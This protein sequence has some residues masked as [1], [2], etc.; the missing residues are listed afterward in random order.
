MATLA[1]AHEARTLPAA[2]LRIDGPVLAILLAAFAIQV[3]LVLNADLGWLL[4]VCEKMLGG[5]RLGRDVLELNP[6]LS[7]LI[8]MPAAYLGTLLPVPAHLIV[9]AMVLALAWGST[10]LILAG[11]GADRWDAAIRRRAYLAL[12]TLMTIAPGATFAQRE[13]IAM[14]G[15]MPFVAL[16]AARADRLDHPRPAWLTLLAGLGAGLAMCLKPHFAA[17]AGLPLLWAA[18]RQ[19]SLRPLFGR[20][21]WTAAALVIAYFGI[22]LLAY[23]EYFSVY[24]KWAAL[25][26]LPLRKPVSF[27]LGA[28]MV[29]AAGGLAWAL[30]LVCGRDA[31][32]W[33]AAAPW[34]LAALGGFLS[35]VVQ[36]KGFAYMRLPTVVFALAGVVLSPACLDGSWWR[37]DNRGA[38]A[39]L[40]LTTLPLLIWLIPSN[41]N[42]IELQE[43]I[44]AA[45]PPHPTI[46]TIGS[47]VGLSEPLVRNLGGTLGA[48][49]GSQL[50]SGGA[51]V[52]LEGRRLHGSDAIDARRIVTMERDLLRRDLLRHRPDVLLIDRQRF[53]KPFSWEAWARADPRI[54]AELDRHYR[55]L[56]LRKKVAV[57]LRRATGDGRRAIEP[58][59]SR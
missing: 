15:L 41:N 2:T 51:L 28:D 8:Y 16:A 14:I 36:G 20:E 12:L 11:L 57:W 54:A 4:T 39:R 43:P 26:Y 42:F 46:L 9:V 17:P 25:T 53:D 47:N 44:R 31:A 52:M 45:A 37:R 7:V 24:P 6:P 32:R 18:H 10:R 35:Y 56:T 40:A 49:E 30:V 58:I 21:C 22:A 33:R 55:F 48:T 50:M 1:Q 5:A 13:H 3:P 29:C 38:V 19:K 27:L 59:R 23:P 34:L